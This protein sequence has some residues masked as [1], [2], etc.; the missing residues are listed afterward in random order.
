MMSY[1][2]LFCCLFGIR[3]GIIAMFACIKSD[4][5]IGAVNM[6]MMTICF[7]IIMLISL[8]QAIKYDFYPKNVIS[9][10]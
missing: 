5:L 3:K 1:I 6:I 2:I 7:I 10:L 4:S 9:N 8:N